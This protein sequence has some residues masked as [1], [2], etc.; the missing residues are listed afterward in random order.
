MSC[1]ASVMIVL[2]YTVVPIEKIGSCRS[3]QV[4]TLKASEQKTTKRSYGTKRAFLLNIT[5]ES[6]LRNVKLH[7][8]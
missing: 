8:Y 1:V 6:F 4:Y 3:H 7:Q 5:Y 2:L